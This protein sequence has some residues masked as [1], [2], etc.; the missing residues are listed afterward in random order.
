MDFFDVPRFALRLVRSNRSDQP[1]AA[2][3]PG[4][5]S[6]CERRARGGGRD[7]ARL[8]EPAAAAGTTP[9]W[10]SPNETEPAMKQGRPS[11]VG[12]PASGPAAAGADLSAA[13]ACSE[14]VPV[15]IVCSLMCRE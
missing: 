8:G 4:K 5:M 7:H 14:D 13:V 15:L 10:A 2:A 3:S 9:A 12:S 11:A 1:D 6:D